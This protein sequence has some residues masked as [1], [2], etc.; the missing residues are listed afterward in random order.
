MR[1]GGRRTAKGRAS[2]L[3]RIKEEQDKSG[4]VSEEAIEQIAESMMLSRGD[5]Y[6]VTT[7]YSFLSTLPG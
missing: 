5:V 1:K 7:F 6:G 2:L 3:G 4:Y